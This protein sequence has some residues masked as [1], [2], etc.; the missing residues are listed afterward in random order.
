MGDTTTIQLQEQFF[1][2]KEKVFIEQ[3]E[4]SVSL[5]RYD[6]GVCGLRLK[7]SKG[8]LTMLPFQGQQIWRC[9][10]EGR[11]LT[12][13]SMF[14]QP[15]PTDDYL[16]TYG[17]FFVHCGATAMGVPSKEDT[18][19][20]HGELP[21]TRYKK[22][23]VKAGCDEGGAFIGLGGEY[24]HIVAFNHHYTFEPFVKL[25]AASS[26]FSISSRLTNL[27]QTEMEFMYMAHMNF[28]PA[29]GGRIVYSA[30][31]T[32]EHTRVVINVPEH[33]KSSHPIEDFRAFL[34]S[35]KEHPEKHLSFTPDLIL[36]PEV[37]FFIDY[38]ADAEGF[39]HSMHVM[40]DGYAHF[41]KHRLA[42]LN[43][44]VRWIARKS[45][46]DALGLFLP[47]TARHQGYQMEKA[48]GNIRVLQ[49]GE[50]IEFC[51]EGGLLAPQ[52]AEQEEK[53][54][55]DILSATE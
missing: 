23:W 37:L 48:R 21:N 42:E 46:E 2:E 38:L 53:I 40:P 28:C 16:S 14:E 5:F 12:M 30:P 3:G 39:A 35:L 41:I 8:Q 49:G 1:S 29:D 27:K 45:D 52:A 13:R 6:T 43:K 26:Q 9:E 54:I 19:P 34:E 32:P 4:L 50:S 7:N 36:D 20:L 47:A 44:G 33:I 55:S 22:V 25:Y 51:L 17:A 31:C 11:E 24:E 10:F 18:H 15:V